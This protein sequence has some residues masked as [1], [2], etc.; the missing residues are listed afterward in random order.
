MLNQSASIDSLF[1]ALA[2]PTRRAIVDQLSR[3]QA[4]VSDIAKP[5]KMS[6]AAVVQHIQVL[7][8]CGVIRTHK[9]GRVRT[10]QVEPRSF[11]VVEQW[12]ASRRNMW[13]SHFDRLGTV[14]ADGRERGTADHLDGLAREIR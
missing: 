12:L 1:R 6:L 3:N 7:E 5:L 2:D 13:E 11:A 4:S 8:E 10:C 14:L 9:T